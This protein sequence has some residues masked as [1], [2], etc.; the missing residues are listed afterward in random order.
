MQLLELFEQVDANGDRTIEWEEFSEYCIG[1]GMIGDYL[2][3]TALEDK[4]L[5]REDWEDTIFR[6]SAITCIKYIDSIDKVITCENGTKV[7]KIFSVKGN[8]P[9]LLFEFQDPKGEGEGNSGA[10]NKGSSILAIEYIA[11]LEVIVTSNS[12]FLL[13]FWDTKTRDFEDASGDY[14]PR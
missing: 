8:T 13:S 3:N 14:P 1:A 7:S 9:E 5:K 12:E 11:E 10:G 4:F 2:K 6:G